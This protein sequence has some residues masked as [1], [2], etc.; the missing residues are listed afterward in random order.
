MFCAWIDARA[1]GVS[2]GVWVFEKSATPVCPMVADCCFQ[3]FVVLPSCTKNVVCGNGPA[4]LPV[5]DC[6]PCL[7]VPCCVLRS[8]SMLIINIRGHVCVLSPPLDLKIILSDDVRMIV[9]LFMAWLNWY[10]YNIQ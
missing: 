7:W 6:C 3:G 4:A 1:L 9:E 2:L 8:S 5:V 10:W